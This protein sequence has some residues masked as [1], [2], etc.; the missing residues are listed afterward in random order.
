MEEIITPRAH[1]IEISKYDLDFDP[2]ATEKQLNFVVQRT[3][4]RLK[5]DEAFDKLWNGVSKVPIRL[6]YHYYN[7]GY[8]GDGTWQQQVS[9]MA[10]IIKGLPFHAVAWD[11]EDAF[12]ILN[13]QAA[14]NSY[15]AIKELEQKTG[16]PALLYTSLNLYNTYIYPTIASHKLD[17]NS[18][19]LWIA[20]WLFTPDPNKSPS[21]PKGRTGRYW[22][23]WQYTDKGR[24]YGTGRNF[25]TDLDVFNGTVA[26]M[27]SQF[28]IGG[29]TPPPPPPGGDLIYR[30]TVIASNGLNVRNEPSATATKLFAMPNGTKIEA[31]LV[32]NKW[33]HIVKINNAAVSGANWS[34]EGESQGYIRTDEVVNDPPPPPAEL[35]EYF[36]AHD[37]NGN[38]LARYNK[39]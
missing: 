33:W 30:G 29:G 15:S 11:F 38:E 24:G 21:T 9:L 6:A 23:I 22:D 31:D 14:V 5:K 7:F 10:S 25:P 37:K 28:N 8:P 1:G 18:I 34:Y 17:W 26:E 4:Y 16:L 13:T 36:I 39:A 2:E 20:Q 27:K 12:N 35:P 32:Q 3:S 19:P